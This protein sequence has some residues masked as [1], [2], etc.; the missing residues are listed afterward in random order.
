M[1]V[2]TRIIIEMVKQGNFI[3]VSAIC[4]DTGKEV[5]IVGDPRAGNAALKA[6]AVKKLK[7]VMSKHDDQ[8]AVRRGIEV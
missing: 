4:E 7:Y 8:P 2:P 3:K 6:L 1:P 5:S